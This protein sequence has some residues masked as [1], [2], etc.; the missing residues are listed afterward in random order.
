MEKVLST[1]SY[2]TG[3]VSDEMIICCELPSLLF[4]SYHQQTFHPTAGKRA[5]PRREENNTKMEQRRTMGEIIIEEHS[6]I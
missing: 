3:N 1:M 5:L 6:F 2:I 4:L